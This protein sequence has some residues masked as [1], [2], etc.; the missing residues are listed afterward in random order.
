LG[1]E[2]VS[3]TNELYATLAGFRR[4]AFTQAIAQRLSA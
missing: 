4:N 2:F 1:L 3:N